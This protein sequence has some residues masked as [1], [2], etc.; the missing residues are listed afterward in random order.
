MTSDDISGQ[1]P[2]G[3]RPSIWAIASGTLLV[4]ILIGGSVAFAINRTSG[5]HDTTPTASPTLSASTPAAPRRGEGGFG[6]PE[7]DQFGRRVDIPNNPDGQLREQSTRQKRIGDHDWLTAAPAG[8][9]EQGGWQRIHGA[10]V[11]ISSS[12]GP[13]RIQDGVPGGY[14]R[15]PQG[16]ALAASMSVYQVGARPGDRAVLRARMV[17]TS[18]D[19]ASFDDMIAKGKLPRQQPE[20]VTRA[21]I[22]H[23]AFRIDTYADDLAIVRLAVRGTTT[24]TERSWVTVTV[25]MVWYDDDWRLRGSGGQLPTEVVHDLGGWTQW[26]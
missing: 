10:V 9:R 18:A 11:P 26:S 25:P 3:E 17:L 6:I 21:L 5:G 22:A 12:D 19:Q 24:A 2:Q 8:L 1:K 15:T 20:V 23:D 4:M 16:A 7:I 14:A 13:T